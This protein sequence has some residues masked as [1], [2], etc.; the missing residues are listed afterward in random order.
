[1]T[2]KINRTKFKEASTGRNTRKRSSS[3]KRE[4]TQESVGNS[5]S[6]YSLSRNFKKKFPEIVEE[7]VEQSDFYCNVTDEDDQQLKLQM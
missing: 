1:L 6:S 5:D 7:D 4:D 2:H 3:S